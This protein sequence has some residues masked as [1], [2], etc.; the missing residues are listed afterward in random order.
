MRRAICEA[1]C[2][3]QNSREKSD[4]STRRPPEPD[5]ISTP[6]VAPLREWRWNMTRPAI[7]LSECRLAF[8][9]LPDK[10]FGLLSGEQGT[11]EASAKAP[12]ASQES[13]ITDHASSLSG[14]AQDSCLGH[15]ERFT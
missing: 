2:S 5:D 11:F 8:I 14:I 1:F 13:S 15:S 7:G 12:G 4:R 3:A 10:P 6:G 9:H